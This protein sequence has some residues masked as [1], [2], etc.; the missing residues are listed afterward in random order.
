MGLRRRLRRSRT[1][2]SRSTC[3]A[4]RS[5]ASSRRRPTCAARTTPATSPSSTTRRS[6][7]DGNDKIERGVNVDL[8]AGAAAHVRTICRSGDRGPAAPRLRSRG[9]VSHP[10]E[11]PVPDRRDAGA[12]LAAAGDPRVAHRQPLRRAGS[13]PAPSIDWDWT[14]ID[15]GFRLGIS[16]HTDFTLEYTINRAKAPDRTVEPNEMLATFRVGF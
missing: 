16:D 12:Q 6:A 15:A 1:T 14:K 4:G 10:A 11:R 13:Y 9:R 8:L 7:F 5:A 3:S 2:R